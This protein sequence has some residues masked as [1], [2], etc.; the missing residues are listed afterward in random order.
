MQTRPSSTRC[1]ARGSSSEAGR[2][3]RKLMRLDREFLDLAAG[4]QRRD[5][6]ARLAAACAPGVA[7]L[8]AILDRDAATRGTRLLGGSLSGAHGLCGAL[9]G[10][11]AE[12]ILARQF[13]VLDGRLDAL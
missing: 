7:V 5:E 1:E 4:L 12:K 8:V 13:I 9:A 6:P 11:G 3:F 10:L 2:S